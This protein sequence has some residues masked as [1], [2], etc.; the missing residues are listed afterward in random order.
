MRQPSHGPPFNSN[1]EYNGASS[2][3][4]HRR[5]TRE[6][7][8]GVRE[9]DGMRII[10]P[11]DG[12][13]VA[14]NRSKSRE[15]VSALETG[16]RWAAPDGPPILYSHTGCGSRISH[17]AVCAT[18]GSLEDP[19]AVDARPGPGMPA[20]HLERKRMLRARQPSA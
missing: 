10:G 4:T 19:A 17:E 16:D 5:M 12:A 20:E 18:H 15:L 9:L 14:G 6:E 8:V 2:L 1:R 13:F 11:A 3:A 7:V